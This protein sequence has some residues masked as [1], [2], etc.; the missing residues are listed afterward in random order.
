MNDDEE[1]QESHNLFI[2]GQ[3]TTGWSA[4]TIVDFLGS[5]LD[6]SEVKKFKS[7]KG[8]LGKMLQQAERLFAEV[9]NGNKQAQHV[10]MMGAFVLLFTLILLAIGFSAVFSP[11]QD[12]L[13]LVGQQIEVVGVVSK[14]ELNGLVGV[15][16]RAS[17]Q[18]RFIV[19]VQVRYRPKSDVRTFASLYPSL[20]NQ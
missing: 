9:Q 14:P 4:D 20:I 18:D 15:V 17:D 10:A 6:D 16:Q 11:E 13:D 7:D 8:P 12:S 5:R 1:V 19:Q 3:V 2:E